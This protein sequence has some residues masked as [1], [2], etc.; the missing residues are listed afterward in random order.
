MAPA[1]TIERHEIPDMI[2]FNG[3]KQVRQGLYAGRGARARLLMRDIPF[4]MGFRPPKWLGVP[5]VTPL[6]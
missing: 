1:E 4:D 6:R 5:P 2:E 3:D